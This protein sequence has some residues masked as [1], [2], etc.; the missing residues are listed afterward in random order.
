MIFRFLDYNVER[1]LP[2]FIK[3]I[4]G[5]LEIWLAWFMQYLMMLWS[6]IFKLV[7]IHYNFIHFHC[8]KYFCQNLRILRN[9]GYFGHPAYISSRKALVQRELPSAA[10]VDKYQ[11]GWYSCTH[12]SIWVRNRLSMRIACIHVT[13]LRGIF[14]RNTC[15][16]IYNYLR[17]LFPGSPLCEVKLS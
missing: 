1:F 8:Y 13:S 4:L 5:Q 2:N 15:I 17:K 11:V 6:K 10:K 14:F 7:N 12:G 3:L 9:V 16:L